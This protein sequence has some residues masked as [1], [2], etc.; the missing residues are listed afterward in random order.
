[1]EGG[2]LAEAGT[3]QTLGPGLSFTQLSCRDNSHH[4]LRG[5]HPADGTI[6]SRPESVENSPRP[7]LILA[8]A[9][10]SL[11]PR[12]VANIF[13]DAN[14]AKNVSDYS[15]TQLPCPGPV[16]AAAL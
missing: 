6:V 13:R 12:H 5:S 10:L 1:M 14:S 4:V 15:S 2:N 9:Y 11:S 7:L 8:T 16:L 3:L